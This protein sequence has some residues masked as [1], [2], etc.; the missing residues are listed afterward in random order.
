VTGPKT[1]EGATKVGQR[2]GTRAELHYTRVSA[3][4]VRRVLDLIRGKGVQEADDILRFTE[5]DAGIL[6]RKLLAS[7]VANAEHNDQQAPD[8]LFVSACFA[9]EGPTMKRFRPRARGRASRILKRTC[10]ITIVVARLSDEMLARRREQEAAR[11]SSARARRSVASQAAARRE[12][13]ARSRQ[14]AA[15]ARGDVADEHEGHDHGEDDAG[16]PYGEGSAAPLDDGGAPEGYEIKGNAQS[17]LYHVPGSRYYKATKAEAYFATVEDAERAGFSPTAA[18][19]AAEEDADETAG[20]EAEEVVDVLGTY[21]GSAKATADEP[22]GDDTAA[23]AGPAGAVDNPAGAVDN[24]ADDK[25]GGEKE[26]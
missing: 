25:A 26:A 15:A 22:T 9:D 16:M 8:E 24:T 13:V 5:R 18:E 12:R 7:A 10:H 4:K 14:A 11:P 17:M 2:T 19:A 20:H 3:T 21:R 1:N 23:P 6:V